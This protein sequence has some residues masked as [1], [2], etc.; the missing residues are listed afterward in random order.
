M[1][2]IRILSL[3][4][5]LSAT[6]ASFAFGIFGNTGLSGGFRWDSTARTMQ[7]VERSL[8]GGLRYSVQGGSYQAYR[9]TFSWSGVAPTV[10]AFQSAVQSAFN[11][12]TVVDPVSGLGTTISFTEDLGT[13]TST[14]L[15]GGVRMGAEIDLMGAT[16]GQTFNVGDGGLR[17]EAARGG[18]VQCRALV[19]VNNWDSCVGSSD[20]RR[21]ASWPLRVRTRHFTSSSASAAATSIP[22]T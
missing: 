1:S 21:L 12:W 17:A 4:I 18:D 14:Q 16:S 7:G 6:S 13:A 5:A 3:G 10:A 15:I 11:D 22:A 8:Q 19:Q 2:S 9:D 20:A